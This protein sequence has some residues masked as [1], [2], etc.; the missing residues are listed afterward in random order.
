M[1]VDL[2]LSKFLDDNLDEK[3]RSSKNLEKLIPLNH[4]INLEYFF[5]Y[6]LDNKIHPVDFFIRVKENKLIMKKNK[7][8][9]ED[10]LNHS[11]ERSKTYEYCL[12]YNLSYL[13]KNY[14]KIISNININ[15]DLNLDFLET[16]YTNFKIKILN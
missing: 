10:T 13:I 2:I 11:L 16:I 7:S 9:V 14:P 12:L 6:C 4:K 3:I 15:L 1:S 8:L 5:E